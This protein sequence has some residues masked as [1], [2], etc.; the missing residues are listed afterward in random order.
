[1]LLILILQF[2]DSICGTV[3]IRI[4]ELDEIEFA[5]GGEIQVDPPLIEYS[6]LTLETFTLDHDIQMSYLHIIFHRH[7]DLIS[8][9]NHIDHC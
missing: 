5:I 7:L 1:M 8:L 3:Q 2:A 4:P 6:I 9:E